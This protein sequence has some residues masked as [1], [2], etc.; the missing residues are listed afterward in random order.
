MFSVKI[1]LLLTYDL[2]VFIVQTSM[3][4]DL[5]CESLLDNICDFRQCI[6]HAFLARFQMLPRDSAGCVHVAVVNH[7]RGC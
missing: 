4:L 1:R 7:D 6:L 3:V 5:L 2:C